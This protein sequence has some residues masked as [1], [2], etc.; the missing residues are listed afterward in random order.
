MSDPICPSVSRKVKVIIEAMMRSHDTR[1]TE[2]YVR[3]RRAKL[4]TAIKHFMD[5]RTRPES[6]ADAAALEPQVEW[7]RY[8]QFLRE[9]VRG[10][11]CSLSKDGYIGG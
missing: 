8:M 1:W 11:P 6:G 9:L 4:E 5:T 7:L 2:A 3:A 10:K